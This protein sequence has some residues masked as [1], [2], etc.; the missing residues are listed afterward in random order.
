MKLRKIIE[1]ENTIMKSSSYISHSAWKVNISTFSH[2][3]ALNISEILVLLIVNYRY[4][5]F[6]PS[7]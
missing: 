3:S 7:L 4:S 5:E 6:T 1:K 2:N